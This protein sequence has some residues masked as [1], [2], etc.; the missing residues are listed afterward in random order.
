MALTEKQKE[1]QRKY[2]ERKKAAGNTRTDEV[3]EREREY[4]RKYR[5]T[6]PEALS[7]QRKRQDPT[8]R[9]DRDVV[10]R[11]NNRDKTKKYFNK[12]RWGKAAY[13][14]AK[15]RAK[16]KRIPFAI[17]REYVNSIT[18]THCPVL[19]IELIPG[20]ENKDT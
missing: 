18:P 15:A 12:W 20:A 6:H 7:E 10:W 4:N 19:G 11:A 1:Y 13:D 3:R 14:G 9:K 8:K 16:R 17:T 2:Y 5:A